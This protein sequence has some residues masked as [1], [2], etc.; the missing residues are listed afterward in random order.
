MVAL[1]V[2]L[3]VATIELILCVS[4]SI[5][6]TI[7]GSFDMGDRIQ[8]KDFRGDVIDQNLHAA[9]ILEAGPGKITH[10][11]TGRRFC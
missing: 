8:I 6:K 2:S 3:V 9:T 4:G 1:P 7:S 11:R 5:L 10:H